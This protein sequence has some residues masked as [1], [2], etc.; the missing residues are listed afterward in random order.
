MTYRKFSRFI[1]PQAP[2]EKLLTLA[3]KKFESNFIVSCLK[4]AVKNQRRTLVL[5]STRKKDKKQ[6]I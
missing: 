6:L 4:K 5:N 1:L 2:L 3:R